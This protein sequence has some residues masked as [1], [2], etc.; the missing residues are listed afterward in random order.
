MVVESLALRVR[1]PGVARLV[2]IVACAAW[3]VVGA[4]VQSSGQ[5][6]A[7]APAPQ[8]KVTAT[9]LPQPLV[10]DGRL[11]DEI[12]K[13][14]PATSSF[15]QQE[16]REGQPASEKTD[17]WVFFDDQNIYISGHCW[18]TQPEREVAK[19][20]RRDHRDIQE[21]DSFTVV[22]DTFFDRRNGFY[23]QTNPLGGLRDEQISD[24]RN[25]NPDWNAVWDARTHRD[26]TGW[27]VEMVVPLKSLR[28]AASGEQ[29]WGMNVRRTIRWK[30]EISYLSPVPASYGN[31]G[32]LKVSSGAMLQGINLPAQ[33]NNIELKPYVKTGVL[34]DPTALPSPLSNDLQGDVGIDAKYGLTKGLNAD[35]TVNTDFAQVENDETQVN[36]GRTSV[37]YPEKRD[38]FLEG[39]GIFAFGGVSA[40]PPGG[41]GN[42]SIQQDTAANPLSPIVF[43]SRQIG[44]DGGY[45]VPIRAG[46]RVAGRAGRYSLG[47]L[48]IETGK[49]D[50]TKAV[51]TNFSVVRVRRDVFRRGSIG[52]L[53]TYRPQRIGGAPGS[54]EVYGFDTTLS[55]FQNLNINSYFSQSVTP[56]VT[57]GDTSYL[58]KV[59]NSLD[60]W[61]VNFE[62]LMVGEHFNPEIGFLRRSAFARTFGQGR[63]S[64]RPKRIKG[65]RKLVYQGSVDYLTNPEGQLESREVSGKFRIDFA[66]GDQWES[67]VVRD[68]ELL[69]KGFSITRALGS[70]VTVPAGEYG[71]GEFRSIYYIAPQRVVAGRFNF[72]RG[73]YYN[74]NRTEAGYNGRVNL[75][76]KFGLEP[77]IQYDWIDLPVGRF[78]TKLVGA[79]VGLTLN[80]R[81][82]FSGLVQYSS[83]ASSL[84]SNVRFRWEYQPGSDFFVVYTDGR[85]TRL[86]GFPEMQSRS[87]VVKFTKLMRF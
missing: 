12:Y 67:E 68:Y 70:S 45:E 20:M 54:N 10:I 56:G 58:V 7:G 78:T 16:P 31:R 22:L 28:Y 42:G 13:Q 37:L 40:R 4:P 27:T 25:A 15:T 14:V 35:F 21:G 71:F 72:I 85:D 63:F 23:F 39:Q 77:R 76:S 19:E 65:I 62:R 32:V 26:D 49:S 6:A 53:G 80:P 1:R 59:D 11:D 83:A 51:S 61:G 34:T 87:L 47:L 84:S 2:A 18:D 33:S 30:N 57:K 60:R 69:E 24:E 43:F 48:N 9:K 73:T 29:I 81:M 74:G 38:F 17:V 75:G 55:F 50:Q 66:S 86:P 52:F 82:A 41:S 3:S 8:I 5:P 46:A 44:L 36:F 64:P 79:R